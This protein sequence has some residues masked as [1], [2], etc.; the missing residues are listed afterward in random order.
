VSIRK[1]TR[2]AALTGGL[3]LLVVALVGPLTTATVL[4]GENPPKPKAA[5]P[6]GPGPFHPLDSYGSTVNDNVVLKWNDQALAAI[7]TVSPAP[8]VSARAL[9]VMNT[10]IYDA[11]T[12]YDATAVPTR[13]TGWTRQPADERTLERKS[14][15]ISYAAHRALSDLFPSLEP[16]FTT[17]RNNLGYVDPPTGQPDDPATIGTAAADAVIAARRNDGANQ[18]GSAPGSVS[19]LPYSDYTGYTPPSSPTALSW[20]PLPGQSF[21]VPHWQRVTPFALTSAGQ[22][23]PSGPTL[24]KSDG[25]YEKAVDEIIK[26]SAKLDDG[27]KVR[28]EYWS[29]GPKTEQ[30]PGHWMLFT[31]AT[32]RKNGH[33]IDQAAK[34]HF[35]VSNALL[36]AGITSWNAKRS[37]EFIRPI[38]AVRTLKAG[39]TIKAWAGPNKGTRTI[40]AEEFVSY[41]ATP[42]HPDYVSG[43]ST[44]SG[45]AA[46]VLRLFTGSN[47]LQMSATIAKGGSVI[48]PGSVPA[49][50]VKLTWP[51]YTDAADEAGLSRLLGGI[52]FRDANR[53]GLVLGNAVGSNTWS[54]AQTYFTGTAP[55]GA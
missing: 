32:S 6:I 53:D 27:T 49:A 17:F 15:A 50:A 12:A 18:S 30:P 33:T 5:K 2:T 31:G 51:T 34:L 46:R 4:A 10:S 9:A 47:T 20:R 44:F 24:K 14:M 7:R 3:S 21:I 8:P 55:A 13:R 54:K 39:T 36:D 52:H 22:F 48:E 38:T 28:A 16:T 40:P 26:F 19:G 25:S 23:M 37:Y 35:A 1:P 41:I 42:P 29:D 45:A 11:W 43:H